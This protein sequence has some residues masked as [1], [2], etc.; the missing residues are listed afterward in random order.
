MD[1]LHEQDQLCR[2][3]ESYLRGHDQLVR[4]FICLDADIS[5]ALRQS[6]Y[7]R[8]EQANDLPVFLSTRSK[9]AML[10]NEELAGLNINQRQLKRS[11]KDKYGSWTQ[12]PIKE[13]SKVKNL[14]LDYR[15]AER[16]LYKK[17]SIF[18]T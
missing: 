14:Y 5:D 17:V 8:M 16:A 6:S 3:S 10:D 13:Q 7:M 9:S 4:V 12:A 15:M 11:L 18:I 2:L 1:T